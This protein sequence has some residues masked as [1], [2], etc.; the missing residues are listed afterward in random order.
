MAVSLLKEAA[1]SLLE[2]LQG[3]KETL[4][5]SWTMPP[6]EAVQA[7]RAMQAI[8]LSCKYLQAVQIVKYCMRCKH[9][10]ALFPNLLLFLKVLS[11][12]MQLH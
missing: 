4:E 6:E 3:V 7:L 2:D 12:K 5:I 10:A 9:C 11:I 8:L 1:W